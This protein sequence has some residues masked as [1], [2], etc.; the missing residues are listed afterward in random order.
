M[1]E[2]YIEVEIKD[3]KSIKTL[4]KKL[5]VYGITIDTTFTPKSLNVASSNGK[6]LFLLKVKFVKKPF[7]VIKA[8]PS[9]VNLWELKTNI[10]FNQ[11]TV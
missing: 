10:P 1:K 11:T 6:R 2:I 3:I 9:I 8:H 7:D 4:F 5:N